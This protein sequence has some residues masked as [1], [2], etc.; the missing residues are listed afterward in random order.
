MDTDMDKDLGM[1][2]QIYPVSLE[3]ADPYT[4]SD[5]TCSQ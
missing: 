4:T 3:D 5:K 1:G 2:I